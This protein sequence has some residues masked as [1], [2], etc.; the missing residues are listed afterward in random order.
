MPAKTGVM[1]QWIIDEDQILKN[2]LL[3]DISVKICNENGNRCF[4]NKL[5]R[6]VS[7][8]EEDK[9]IKECDC[10]VDCEMVHFFTSMVQVPFQTQQGEKDKLFDP[11]TKSGTLWNYLT[12]PENEFQVEIP[13]ETVFV[14]TQIKI[15]LSFPGQHCEEPFKDCL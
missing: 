6:F 2:F 15:Y 13:T 14:G 9:Y 5:R 11:K 1:C 10:K 12:D 4:T 8:E 7:R 3:P